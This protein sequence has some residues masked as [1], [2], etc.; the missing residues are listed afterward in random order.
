M[1]KILKSLSKSEFFTSDS[2]KIEIQPNTFYSVDTSIK[3][4]SGLP[5]SGYFAIIMLDFKE[6]E[7]GRRIKWITDFSKTDKTYQIKFQPKPETKYIILSYRFNIET[8]VRSEL[9]IELKDLSLISLLPNSDQKEEYD[10][11]TEFKIPSFLPL[12]E[13]EEKDLE[14]KI[15]WLAAP[16]R[17]GTTWLGTRLLNHEDNIIWHEP[18]IGLHLGLLRGALMPAKDFD[19]KNYKFDRILDMNSSNDQYFFSDQHKNNWLPFLR[20]LILA[21]TYSQTQTISKNIIIKDPVGSNGMDIILECLPQ[22]KI[23]FLV[24]DGRDAI[25]SR[26]DMHKPNS[27]ANLRPL[28]TK[29]D[30]T[31][32]IRY[33]SQ[34][35]T[36]NMD[37]IKKAFDSHPENLRYMIK[38][39]DL[40]KNTFDELK[41]I[42]KFINIKTNDDVLKKL[43][44][45]HDFKNIPD[46]EK[47][48]GKFN[49]LA[50]PGGWRA[51]FDEEEQKLMISIIGN[52]LE[53]YGYSIN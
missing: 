23:L 37:N 2:K 22:S 16:P 18:W 1:S 8:P 29:R 30:R 15:T 27:W 3:G 49:R 50:K 47:G 14:N 33:Y 31:D 28:S 11:I 17:S 46:S 13:N 21:R 4:I 35:W 24:R 43:V 42:Y 44:Q 53:K 48:A 19:Q 52:T 5:Y 41:K 32:A 12:S 40:K 39:E 38:Y 6:R 20:K 45:K 25:D 26:M 36:V 51:N 10:K 34:L 7:I 9:K